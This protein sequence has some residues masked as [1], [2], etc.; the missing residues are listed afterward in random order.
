MYFDTEPS[1]AVTP[2]FLAEA[3]AIFLPCDATGGWSPTALEVN[4]LSLGIGLECKA[5]GRKL[6]LHF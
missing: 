5:E 6:S 4:S 3:A 2:R 1:N